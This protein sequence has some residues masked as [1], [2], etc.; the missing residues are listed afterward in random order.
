M[1]CN[2][3]NRFFCVFTS[4][5]VWLHAKK[6]LVSLV[7]LFSV[8]CQHNFNVYVGTWLI[9]QNGDQTLVVYML[10]LYVIYVIL[11]L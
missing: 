3:L 11:E 8:F 10:L 7:I 1:N 2:M 4:E 6:Y 9:L 5:S